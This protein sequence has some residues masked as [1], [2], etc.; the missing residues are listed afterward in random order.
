MSSSHRLIVCDREAQ[1]SSWLPNRK[2]ALER[3]SEE[4]SL[5][6]PSLGGGM[7]HMRLQKEQGPCLRRVES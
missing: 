1:L 2:A 7:S 6:R 3:P 4:R 5:E